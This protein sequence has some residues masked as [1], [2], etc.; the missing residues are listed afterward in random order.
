MPSLAG[1]LVEIVNNSGA[2]LKIQRES[3]T[4]TDHHIELK[5]G[6]SKVFRCQP[7]PLNSRFWEPARIS[8]HLRCPNGRPRRTYN[9]VAV[10]GGTFGF[11]GGTGIVGSSGPSAPVLTA[12]ASGDGT[13]C[14]L[15][16]HGGGHISPLCGWS[17]GTNRDSPARRLQLRDGNFRTTTSRCGP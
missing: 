11:G 7:V 12:G 5:D 13:I 2:L 15:D 10:D 16:E 4:A 1:R 6:Q 9:R 17:L 8:F 14:W 3:D